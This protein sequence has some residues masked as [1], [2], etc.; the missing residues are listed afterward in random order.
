[1]MND[2]PV[3]EQSEKQPNTIFHP[4]QTHEEGV[5]AFPERENQPNPMAHI[6]DRKTLIDDIAGLVDRAIEHGRQL[7]R[8]D[9]AKRL[10]MATVRPARTVAR[11]NGHGGKAPKFGAITDSV[12]IALDQLGRDPDG[13]GMLDLIAHIR[14]SPE[15]SK[16]TNGQLRSAM[17]ALAVGREAI[18]VDR[19]IYRVGPNL[20]APGAQLL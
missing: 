15:G 17:K 13:V 19:G 4:S 6:I 2:V 8:D 20:Q 7:E 12:R 11:A 10:G 3:E 1:M 14:K 18:R 5:Q 9:M 16:Y